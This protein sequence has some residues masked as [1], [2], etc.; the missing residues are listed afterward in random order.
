MI[1]VRRPVL[2]PQKV[3]LTR[4]T[5]ESKRKKVINEDGK[6]FTSG[7]IQNISGVSDHGSSSDVFS[8]YRFP[9]PKIR[10]A[11]TKTKDDSG[12]NGGHVSLPEMGISAIAIGST[13]VVLL[14]GVLL[15]ICRIRWR[16][17]RHEFDSP[18]IFRPRFDMDEVRSL[19]RY[20]NSLLKCGHVMA[21]WRAVIFSEFQITVAAA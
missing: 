20:K 7:D 10:H 4:A 9:A 11:P 5:Q 14:V 2:K 13:V 3:A 12:E 16:K 18:F 17:R 15:C 6:Y 8:R 1:V 19:S 21:L